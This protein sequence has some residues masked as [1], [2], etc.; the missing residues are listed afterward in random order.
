MLNPSERNDRKLR[1][2]L[3]GP[4]PRQ[5]PVKATRDAAPFPPKTLVP[6]AKPRSVAEVRWP[7]L[8][9][10]ALIHVGDWLFLRTQR[11]EEQAWFVN[12]EGMVSYE[13][14]T[15]TASK[16]GEL[17]TGWPS[18]NIYHHTF[19]DYEGRQILV[20]KLRQELVSG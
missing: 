8:F 4:V 17:V 14:E 12:E 18:I 10:A 19:I 3:E 16:W 2:K 20:Q 15:M 13:G 1:K 6:V 11:V 5:F 9:A 7:S